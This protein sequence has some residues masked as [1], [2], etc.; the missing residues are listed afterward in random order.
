MTSTY[1]HRVIQGAESGQ[2]L[3]VVEAYLQGEHG[4]YE[5]VFA[6]LGAQLGATPQPPGARRGGRGPARR[7][8][9]T[10]ACRGRQGRRGAPA[11]GPGRDVAAQGASHARPPGREA[12][13]AGIRARGRSGARSGD[14][15][16]HARADGADP[17]EDPAHL[18][19]GRDAG[20]RAAAPEGDL[21]RHDRLRDRAHRVAP[22][23][24]VAAGADRVERVP[25]AADQRGAAHAA[26]PAHPGRLARAVHAQGLP[27]PEAVLDRGPRHDRADARRDDPA[28]G[29]QRRARGRHRHGASRP[30]QRPRPLPRAARTRR[31]SASSRARPRSRRS[32]RSRR[33]APATSSTTTARRA[34]TSCP[35]SPRS[36][37]GS[38]PTR[39]TSS[40]S[41][42][43]SR[44]PRARSRR[45]A[46]ARTRTWTTTPRSR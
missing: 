42:R 12:R 41:A 2:F 13:P 18:R 15:R 35:T 24:D 37:S 1:D 27:G 6:D 28:G 30:A 31:S 32:R 5:Q 33:A 39:A 25:H 4:F 20:R 23:A 45:P 22:P 3:Q 17:G 43:S 46:K 9:G 44:A 8:A 26:A 29:R 38:S 14:R 19:P 11:G 21:L 10:R 36:S 34:P 40:T 16:P 7:G